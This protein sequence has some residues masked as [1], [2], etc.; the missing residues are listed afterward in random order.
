MTLDPWTYLSEAFVTFLVIVDPFG[1]LPVFIALTAKS[2]AIVRRQ[3][4]LKATIVGGGILILFAFL[5]DWLLDKLKISEGSFQ[6]AGGLLLMLVAYDMIVAEHSGVSSTTK[7]EEREAKSR[8]DLWIFPIAI[9]LIAGP[10]AM[11]SAV[12]VMRPLDGSLMMQMAA[13]GVLVLVLAVNY[14]CLRLSQPLSRLLGLTGANVL[15][16]VF[17]IILAALAVQFVLDGIKSSFHI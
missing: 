10:G 14:L 13:A 16:R 3:I 7:D 6:I 5:G 1:L 9:P 12:I 11:A 17:G 2:D 8:S 15:S 4:A